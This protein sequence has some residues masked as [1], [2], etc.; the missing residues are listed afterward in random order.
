[1]RNVI[2][3]ADCLTGLSLV[4]DDTFDAIVTSPP[5]FSPP[6]RGQEGLGDTPIA[7]VGNLRARL[8]AALLT[9]KETGTLFLHLGDGPQPLRLPWR[10]VNE[11]CDEM[12]MFYRGQIICAAP[13][14]DYVSLFVLTKQRPARAIE[15]V[16]TFSGGDIEDGLA[17][18]ESL[19]RR[20]LELVG[21]KG[22]VLD[23]FMGL[24][25][26]AVAALQMGW[27]FVGFEKN[28][29]RYHQAKKRIFGV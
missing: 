29:F 8:A 20:C 5:F 17:F 19:V 12:G 23:P 18:P 27:G 24:G 4:P 22:I 1:M 11:L 10:V 9:M 7:Y 6:Y 21:Q 28:E 14:G 13:R 15:E 25:T 2:H 3:H 26:T 16:W